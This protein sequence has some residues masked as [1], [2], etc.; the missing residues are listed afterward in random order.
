[1][2]KWDV[3]VLVGM[4]IM[5]LGAGVMINES[6]PME[7]RAVTFVILFFLG[8]SLAAIGMYKQPPVPEGEGS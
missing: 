7:V 8:Y 4:A 5:M 3:L 2:N 6:I 1:M